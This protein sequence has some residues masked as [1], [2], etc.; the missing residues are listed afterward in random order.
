M[1]C[2]TAVTCVL[3]FLGFF[4][5]WSFVLQFGYKSF[6]PTFEVTSVFFFYYSLKIVEYRKHETNRL[7]S[8]EP[9]DGK[10]VH[11]NTGA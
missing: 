7:N 6:M 5:P 3:Q 4:P 11:K 2:G 9:L 8:Q 10:G 1:L